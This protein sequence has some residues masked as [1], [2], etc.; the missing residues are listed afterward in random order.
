[1]GLS[2]VARRF[3]VFRR[4]RGEQNP[5]ETR[6][7]RIT[8][9][10]EILASVSSTGLDALAVDVSVPEQCASIRFQG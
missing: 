4:H 7:P 10:R 5:E 1:M 6:A 2:A 9:T 3:R 8:E